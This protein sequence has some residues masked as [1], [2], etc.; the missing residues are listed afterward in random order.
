M[1]DRV[2]W[3]SFYESYWK[4]L[5]AFARRAG[6]SESDAEDVA[7]ETV[8]KVAQ[9]LPGFVY[10]PA[11]G[12]FRGWLKT[13]ATRRVADHFRTSNRRLPAALA[14]EKEPVI[15]VPPELEKLWDEEWQRH[16][17]E[18]ALQRLKQRINPFHYQVFYSHSAR[19]WP[20][21][22]VS[23]TFGV[24]AG[25]VHVIH[26]RVKPIFEE[27]LRELREEPA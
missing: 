2:A 12:S 20:M 5:F 8:M 16:W 1:E 22:E 7:Q 11:K 15:A 27:L 24:K 18:L 17:L 21:E 3:A 6:L 9:R 19:N 25:T 14:D 13:I 10:D 4:P 26:H 23:R